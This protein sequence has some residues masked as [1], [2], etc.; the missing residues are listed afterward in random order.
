MNFIANLNTDLPNSIILSQ[1]SDVFKTLFEMALPENLLTNL[2]DLLKIPSEKRTFT[3]VRNRIQ[4][5]IEEND[6]LT[7]Q[8]QS[9]NEDIQSNAEVSPLEK[10]LNNP[11]LEHLAENIF[12][13]LDFEDIKVCRDI[14]QSSQQ[15]LDNP[16]FWLRKFRGL[17]KKNQ[18]DWIKDIQ[19]VKNSDK[20]RAI[21]SYLQ[22]N[23]RKDALVDLPCYSSHTVQDDFRKKIMASSEG[24]KESFD[25]PVEI[26]KILA[27]LTYNPN[28]PNDTDMV[29]DT[30]IHKAA[31]YGHTEIVKILATLT[32]NPNV[33]N[34]FG[35]TPIIFAASNWYTEIVKILAPLTD[36]PNA[37]NNYGDTPIFFAATKGHTAIVKIL[38]PLTDDPNAPNNDGDTPIYVAARYGHTE[39]V[40][41]LAFLTDNPNAPNKSGR[42]PS[43]VTKNPEIQRFLESYNPSGKS[44]SIK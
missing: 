44:K 17:S 40:K 42:T 11:G 25:E 31:F 19:S 16:L 29:N 2:M 15:K 27:P 6:R 26:V 5:L 18:K 37:P 8:I 7:A 9:K 30:P 13:N 12:D 33:P 35:N 28:S 36:N 3:E 23:L 32:D 39:I 21:V 1:D 38:A 22:W 34:Y 10:I 41:I 4:T 14:N 24:K 20:E 43:S